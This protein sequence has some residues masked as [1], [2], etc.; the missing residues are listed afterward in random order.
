MNDIIE[1]LKTL[2]DFTDSAKIDYLIEIREA[3][4]LEEIQVKLKIAQ[5]NLEIERLKDKPK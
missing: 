3:L 4:K 5:I 2:E 1:I